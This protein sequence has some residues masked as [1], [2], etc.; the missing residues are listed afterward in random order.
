MELLSEVREELPQHS[1]GSCLAGPWAAIRWR[2]LLHLRG[3]SVARRRSEPT[4][5]PSVAYVI[6]ATRNKVSN[7]E[8]HC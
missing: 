4:A 5:H 7:N 3:S 1:S 8:T 6:S 2:N